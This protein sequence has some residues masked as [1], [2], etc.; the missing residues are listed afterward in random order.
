M[1][2]LPDRPGEIGVPDGS[3]V[4]EDRHERHSCSQELGREVVGVAPH[5][6]EEA[7]DLLLIRKVLVPH[8]ANPLHERPRR[9]MVLPQGEGAGLQQ[10]ERAGRIG[11]PSGGEEDAEA[12]VGMSH[13]M[14]TVTH[15]VG[16]VIAVTQEVL[17]L[18]SGTVPI[19]RRSSTSK[20]HPSSASGRWATHSSAPVASEPCASTT[21][22]P[23][24]QVNRAGFRRGSDQWV[25]AASLASA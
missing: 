4:A 23:V 3:P 24:P 9:W 21:G 17:A 18:G 8:A 7:D 12:A 1:G 14:G 11:P 22:V 5:R 2:P 25:I 10:G 15:E 16:D 20:R 13:E 19:A 6:N